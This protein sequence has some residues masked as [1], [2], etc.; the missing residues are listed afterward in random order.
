MHNI[1]KNNSNKI[2][3]ITFLE[4]EEVRSLHLRQDIAFLARQNIIVKDVFTI[5]KRVLVF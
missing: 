5:F 2:I 4:M 3:V 1:G